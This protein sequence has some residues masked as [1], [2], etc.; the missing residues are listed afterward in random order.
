MDKVKG[1]ISEMKQTLQFLSSL[2]I[3]FYVEFSR[4][5]KKQKSNLE[6]LT[7]LLEDRKKNL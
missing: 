3:T 2:Y 4:D 6:K 5:L 1:E 7:Q